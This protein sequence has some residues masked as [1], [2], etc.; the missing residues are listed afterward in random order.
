MSRH[1]LLYAVPVC[2]SFV[3]SACGDVEAPQPG[4]R[5]ALVAQ[6][7]LAAASLDSYAGEI[8]ARLEPELAFRVGGKISARHVEVGQRVQQDAALAE[9]DPQDMRL[10][11]D[12][13][14]AQAQAAE[15]NLQLAKAERERYRTLLSRQL[16]SQSQFDSA[17]NSYRAAEAQ[18]RRARSELKV[19]DNQA[20]YTVLRAPQSG[21]IVQRTAE[22]GQVVAAGQQ[23]FVLAADGER[24]VSIAVPEQSIKRLSIG[25]E[26]A[27][28]LWSRPGERF[29]GHV[30]E[31]APAADSRSR[32]YAARVAFQSDEVPA[33]LGQSARVFIAHQGDIPLAVP[34]AAVTAEQGQP[35]V[36]VVD[37]Q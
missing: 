9:L 17:E 30:R 8:R 31:L 18:L 24:E 15:A 13:A 25:Q 33:Q 11:R 37:P 32:T 6:P 7:Q 27:V 12:A 16:V 10:Q 4:I 23:V 26:V 29:T 21:V 19:A 2:L 22:V 28:E 35:Y 34:L 5:P 3:L 1:A 36:W 14:T 20:A